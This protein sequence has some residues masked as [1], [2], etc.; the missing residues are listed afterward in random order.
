MCICIHGYTE[1][2]G[3]HKNYKFKV[4]VDELEMTEFG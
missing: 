3:N 1:V 4:A 2:Y